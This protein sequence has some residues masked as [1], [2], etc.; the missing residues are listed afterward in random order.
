MPLENFRY[1]LLTLL[2]LIPAAYADVDDYIYPHQ[3]VASFSNYSTLGLI[4]SPS[5]RFHPAG[6]LAFSWSSLDPYLR[7][8]I[9]AY[10]FDWLEAAYHYTDI[11]NAYYSFTPEFSGSQTYKDKGFDLKVRLIKERKFIPQ[12]AAGVRDF[13]GTGV[14]AAE[15]F[16][17]SKKIYNYDFTLGVGFGIILMVLGL[18]D[19]LINL[20]VE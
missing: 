19:R 18:I 11:N 14:F 3:D 2:A 13:A 12:L 20:F 7:G 17:A 8:A 1:L 9:V 10:P 6:S 5:A 4:Q 16:V 15:Y